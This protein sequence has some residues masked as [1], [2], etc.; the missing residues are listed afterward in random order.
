[1]IDLDELQRLHE[2]A[3][4]GTWEAREHL[5]LLPL[6]RVSAHLLRSWL[7]WPWLVRSR[8]LPFR[9][10]LLLGLLGLLWLLRCALLRCCSFRRC[11]FP[12]RAVSALAASATAAAFMVGIPLLPLCIRGCRSSGR[13]GLRSHG[14]GFSFRF[15]LSRFGRSRHGQRLAGFCE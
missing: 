2:A 13:G 8:L 14:G 1:M 10:P 12:V 9:T 11:C 3:T 6:W 7:I 4:P 5:V 15:W